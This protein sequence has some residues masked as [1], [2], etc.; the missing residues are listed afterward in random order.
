MTI[1]TMTAFTMTE[2]QVQQSV[3]GAQVSTA[4]SIAITEAERMSAG[5]A[6]RTVVRTKN[7]GLCV[8]NDFQLRVAK[9]EIIERVYDTDGGFIFFGQVA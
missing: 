8:Y 2:D 5:G 3:A 6:N 4:L 1:F 7:N 9:D